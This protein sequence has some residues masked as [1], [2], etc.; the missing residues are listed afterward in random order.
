MD[1]ISIERINSLHPKIRDIVGNIYV[2]EVS[3]VLGVDTFCRIAYG[4][5][6]FKEQNELY[7]LGRTKLFSPNGKRLGIV[8]NAK[9]GQS[10]HN[11][12]LAWDIVLIRNVQ[13]KQS[14]VYET[15]VDFDKDGV[16]DWLEVARC[17]KKINAEWGG[18]WKG[19]L[20]DAPHFQITFGRTWKNLLELKRSGNVIVGT[21]YPII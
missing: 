21:E 5:R 15:A 12:G 7:S 3:K 16:S 6:T 8:T 9:A 13:G 11:Y 14:A 20:Y 17:F 19:K 2:D 10:F 1:K 18:D 4:L